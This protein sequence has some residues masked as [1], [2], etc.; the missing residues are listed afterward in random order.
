VQRVRETSFVTVAFSPDGRLLVTGDDAGEVRLWEAESLRPLA[1]LGRIG[2][3]LKSVAFSPD[4]RLVASAGVDRSVSL[5]D[6]AGRRLVTTVGSHQAPVLSLAFSPDGRRL[7]A[8]GQDRSVRLLT[9]HR[10]LWG[11]RIE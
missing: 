9:R 1:R 10:A 8:G 6:V 4:G 11:R 5:W 3:R 2:A 7:A